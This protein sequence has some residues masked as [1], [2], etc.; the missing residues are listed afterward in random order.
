M[1]EDLRETV[2]V[3]NGR[4]SSFGWVIGV[5]VVLILL[6]LFFMYG[7][8]SLF[9]GGAGGGTDTINVDTP[10]NVNVQPTTGQ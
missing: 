2:V 4:R 7:G 9:A 1:V 10:D 6:A 5:V 3:D 8:F